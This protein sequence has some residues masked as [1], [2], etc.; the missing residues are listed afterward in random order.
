MH[1]NGKIVY[2]T[3]TQRSERKSSRNSFTLNQVESSKKIFIACRTHNITLTP[4]QFSFPAKEDGFFYSIFHWIVDV[5]TITSLNLLP[6][7]IF[8]VDIFGRRE[9]VEGGG[10]NYS[11]KRKRD[12]IFFTHLLYIVE[13]IFFLNILKLF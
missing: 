2:C 5:Q 8:M 6:T 7:H 4:E 10:N 12:S 1:K 3:N 9:A 11:G 13:Y